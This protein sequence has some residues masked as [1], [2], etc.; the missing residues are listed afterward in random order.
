MEK[1]T[2]KKSTQSLIPSTGNKPVTSEKESF[3]AFI[4]VYESIGGKVDEINTALMW[5]SIQKRMLDSE[6]LE[7]ALRRAYENE[8]KI[9]WSSV[10]KYCP[11]GEHYTFDGG[12]Y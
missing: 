5:R 10:L 8:Y 3:M 6:T 11:G 7:K 9:T 1:L 4:R 2:R 12:T